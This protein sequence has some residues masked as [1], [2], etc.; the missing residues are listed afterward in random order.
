[1]ADKPFLTVAEVAARLC[2]SL[3]SAYTYL[4]TGLIPYV[5][6]G[7]VKKVSAAAL[8]A[9]ITQNT[10]CGPAPKPATTA[11]Q[12]PGDNSPGDGGDGEATVPS[13]PSAP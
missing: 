3:R 12:S 10:R 2:I 5:Q 1:M 13:P 8:A 6:V 9:F 7:G 11:E 4:N